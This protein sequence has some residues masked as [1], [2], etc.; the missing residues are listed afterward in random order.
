M[1]RTP[2][3]RERHDRAA[4]R[5][6]ARDAGHP[7]SEQSLLITAMVALFAFGAVMVYSASSASSALGASGDSTQYL[8]RYLIL[9]AFGWVAL[10]FC[11]R[12]SLERVRQATPG[13]LV[14]AIALLVVVKLPGVGVE[15][16]GAQRWLG[17][18][19]ARFQ[20]S[21]VAKLAMVLYAAMLIAKNPD[22]VKS[23]ATLANPLL[24]VCGGIFVLV[25]AQPDLGTDLVM[26]A[27]L[28]AILIAAGAQVKDVGK[29]AGGLLVLVI[30]FSL[31]EPYRVA[32]LTAFLNPGADPSGSG[33]QTDQA[34]IAIGSGGLLGSGL[35]ESVQKVFYLPEAHTDM[36]LAVIGEELGMF[37]ITGLALLYFTVGYAGLRAAKNSRDIYARLLALGITSLIVCQA[38]LN[39]FAV[40]G[41]APLT[42]VPLPFVSYGNTN[43]IVLMAAMGLLIN[44]A[45]GRHQARM[46]MVEGWAGHT[47]ERKRIRAARLGANDE[48]L[49]A[50][51]ERAAR[52]ARISDRRAGGRRRRPAATTRRNGHERGS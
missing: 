6:R 34:R 16:N 13:L 52:E 35:G 23:L 39:F 3:E 25:A 47:G 10:R 38:L 29:L 4:V 2:R 9:G 20:P 45:S 17:A 21:E 19:P 27:T 1:G 33:F 12:V 7:T 30:L 50:L 26:C 37:G 40:L 48:Q 49:D 28:F 5:G 42:G 15:V 11:S 14:A 24:Y 22:R 51:E 41:L 43:L 36:I 32:R 18:G 31:V 8:K 44:V 46:T